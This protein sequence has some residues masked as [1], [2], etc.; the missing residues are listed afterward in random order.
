VLVPA[1]EELT[2][3]G[4][5]GDIELT[6]AVGSFRVEAVGEMA[7]IRRLSAYKRGTSW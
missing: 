2:V 1:I 7:W 6:V 5:P 4:V 3:A